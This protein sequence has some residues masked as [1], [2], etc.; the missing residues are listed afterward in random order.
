MGVKMSTF[1]I[2]QNPGSSGTS[3]QGYINASYD[4]L[5]LAFG[6][7]TY[8]ETSADNKVDIEWC[9]KIF[10]NDDE[11][12]INVT[13]YNWKDYDGGKRATVESDY[14]WHIGGHSPIDAVTLKEAF[15]YQLS[16]KEVA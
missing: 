16:Q 14:E 7:P 4:D 10:E 15:V 8:D 9:L 3:L 5:V 6:K 13:I 12:G 11:D 2:E 1:T